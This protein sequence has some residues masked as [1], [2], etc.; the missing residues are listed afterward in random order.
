MDRALLDLLK[1]LPARNAETIFGAVANELKQIGIDLLPASSFMKAHMPEAGLLSERPPTA[2][3]QCDIDLGL[4][5]YV[6]PPVPEAVADAVLVPGPTPRTPVRPFPGV[7]LP[8][9][10]VEPA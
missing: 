5:E 2:T 10:G 8:V 7:P 9:G 1:H 4:I 6:I 3:E